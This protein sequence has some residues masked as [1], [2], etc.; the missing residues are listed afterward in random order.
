MIS[1]IDRIHSD[2]ESVKRQL[3]LCEQSF[4]FKENERLNSRVA[5]LEKQCKEKQILLEQLE[6]TIARQGIRI[7]QLLREQ[8]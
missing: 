5:S 4:L 2:L 6:L 8:K 3:E 1:A 7:G